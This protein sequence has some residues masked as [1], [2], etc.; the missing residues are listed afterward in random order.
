[1]SLG[2]GGSAE[3]SQGFVSVEEALCG[4][5]TS[6]CAKLSGMAR[7]GFVLP[8]EVATFPLRVFFSL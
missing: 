5:L 3:A 6:T 7:S 4:S 8:P 2:R 1:M